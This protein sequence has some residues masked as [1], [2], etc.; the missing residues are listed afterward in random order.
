MYKRILA[1]FAGLLIGAAASAAPVDP[2][3]GTFGDLGAVGS[4]VTFGGTGIPTTNANYETFTDRLGNTL[5]LGLSITPRFSAPTPANDGNGTYDVQPGLAGSPNGTGVFW[6]F[7]FYAELFPATGSG[8]TI[9]DIGL[10]LLYDL[11]SAAG[12]DILDLGVMSIALFPN[13]TS[14]IAQNSQNLFFSYLATGIP[15]FNTPGLNT[16]DPN[17]GEYSFLLRATDFS[18]D[19]TGGVAVIADAGLAPRRVGLMLPR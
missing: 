19:A 2:T 7:S 17:F 10:Q 14:T 13:T 18:P 5:L 9:S 3:A 1:A 4:N 8:L 11:D 12:T 6:N 16:F 15:G